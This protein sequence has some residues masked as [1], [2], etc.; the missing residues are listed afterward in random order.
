MEGAESASGEVHRRESER[1]LLEADLEDQEEEGLE[2]G[3]TTPPLQHS[4]SWSLSRPRIN[5]YMVLKLDLIPFR[6]VVRQTGT[7]EPAR[8]LFSSLT[9]RVAPLRLDL[10]DISQ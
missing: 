4:P 2:D 9:G 5:S 1:G 7:S 3:L 10:S 8:N 6:T